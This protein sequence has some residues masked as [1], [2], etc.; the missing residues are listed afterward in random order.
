MK[1]QT[2][3]IYTFYNRIA[4]LYDG[5]LAL[6]ALLDGVDPTEE[7]KTLVRHLRLRPGQ[8]VLEVGAGTGTNLALCA[9]HL[10]AN[11]FLAGV[12]VSEEM[13]TQCADAL[14]QTN[15]PFGLVRGNA[16][17][18][19]LAT[20]S[21]DVVFTFGTLNLVP[22]KSQAIHEMMRVG[23]AGARIVLSDKS[24]ADLSTLSLRQR[25]L[26]WLKPALAAPPP[27]DYVP[28]AGDDL[29]IRWFWSGS[30]YILSFAN[31]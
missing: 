8:H 12:D 24:L 27:T 4:P 20:G 10:N 16:L 25:F 28:L 22:D 29:T 14:G 6:T 26:L 2:H 18:L 23:R 7:R 15:V 21:M 9:R 11:S 30:A 3:R 5:F 13:L 31:Q 17:H 1:P 19:P